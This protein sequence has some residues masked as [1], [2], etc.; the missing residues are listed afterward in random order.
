MLFTLAI[1][2]ILGLLSKVIFSKIKL[3][4]IIGMLFIGIL[5]GPHAFNILDPKISIISADLRQI[6]LIIILMKAGLSLDIQDLK[7]VGRPEI[8]RASCRERV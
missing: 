1:I 5:L 2:I 3:P 7:K 6:A 8:G 4:Y